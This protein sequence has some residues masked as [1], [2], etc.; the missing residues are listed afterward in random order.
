MPCRAGDGAGDGAGDE[1][2][3][4]SSRHAGQI[5]NDDGD[6]AAAAATVMT[7]VP[8]HWQRVA[9]AATAVMVLRS[10]GGSS[11]SSRSRVSIRIHSGQKK[12]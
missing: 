5:T 2:S 6:C 4:I 1:D 9:V 11:G 12:T 10:S 7:A 3:A 8:V